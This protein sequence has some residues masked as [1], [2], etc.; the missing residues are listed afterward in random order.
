MATYQVVH[1]IRA[2]LRTADLTRQEHMR[3]LA[4]AYA[5][6]WEA[7]NT[8]LSVCEDLLQRGLRKEAVLIEQVEP[9]LLETITALDFAERSTWD[10]LAGTF[11]LPRAAPLRSSVVDALRKEIKAQRLKPAAL[12]P[13]AARPTGVAVAAPAVQPQ[14]DFE[15]LPEAVKGSRSPTFAVFVGFVAGIIFTAGVV[16]VVH[17]AA[18]KDPAAALRA[19]RDGL[20]DELEQKKTALASMTKDKNTTA[21][22]LKGVS[23]ERDQLQK[24][25]AVLEKQLA[26]LSGSSSDKG[27]EILRLNAEVTRLNRENVSLAN[28]TKEFQTLSKIKDLYKPFQEAFKHHKALSESLDKALIDPSEANKKVL[29]DNLAA[30]RE[31]IATRE[32]D[33]Y[34]QYYRVQNIEGNLQKVKDALAEYEEKKGKVTPGLL[35]VYEDEMM[36]VF[37]EFSKE[38]AKYIKDWGDTIVGKQAEEKRKQILD[39]IRKHVSI[40][41]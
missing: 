35:K 14:M 34:R 27:K 20:I 4:A 21:D 7:V 25:K 40:V 2:F 36:N 31:I 10:Q 23:S 12:S 17:L 3:Q 1:D 8:R 33:S 13:I 18:D 16:V 28:D 22:L 19:E 41:P 11:N 37:R 9:P 38:H 24:D 26:T 30:Y 32:L 39:G 5:E 29:K 15:R 6:A